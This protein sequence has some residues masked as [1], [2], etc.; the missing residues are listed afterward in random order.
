MNCAGEDDG[1]L[2]GE[3][4]QEVDEVEVLEFVGD[5]DEGLHEG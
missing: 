2:A 1:G 5:E 3:F 4:V